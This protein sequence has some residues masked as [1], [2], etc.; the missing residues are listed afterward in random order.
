MDSFIGQQRI[1]PEWIPPLSIYIQQHVV[2][3]QST[4]K[5]ETGDQQQTDGLFKG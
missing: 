5:N 3:D 4:A 2:T 1:Q